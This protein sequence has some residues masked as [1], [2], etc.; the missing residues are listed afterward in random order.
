MRSKVFILAALLSG[1]PVYLGAQVPAAKSFVGTVTA[2]K[3]EALQMEVKPDSGD[4]VAVTFTTETIVQRVPAGEKDLKNVSAIKITDVAM[5][6]RVLVSL[7]P[8]GTQARRIVV[9]SANDI[10]RR[11]EQDTQDW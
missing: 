10:A 8:G 9:M 7:L 4:A 3:V 2:F 1:A 6:D 11:N 5:G